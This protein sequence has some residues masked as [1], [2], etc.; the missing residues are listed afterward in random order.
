M[1][2]NIAQQSDER[3]RSVKQLCTGLERFLDRVAVETVL[4]EDVAQQRQCQ[5]DQRSSLFAIIRFNLLDAFAEAINGIA[6]SSFADE[7]SL[8]VIKGSYLSRCNEVMMF[9]NGFRYIV[10]CEKP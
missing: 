3:Y 8:F 5:N 1:I 7:F 9:C 2:Q 6:Q 10:M 4:N